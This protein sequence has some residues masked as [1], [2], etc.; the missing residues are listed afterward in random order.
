LCLPDP[1]SKHCKRQ[2]KIFSNPKEHAWTTTTIGERLNLYIKNHKN[3]L[4]VL[5]LSLLYLTPPQGKRNK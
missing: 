4:V 1:K 5:K 2:Y 3:T